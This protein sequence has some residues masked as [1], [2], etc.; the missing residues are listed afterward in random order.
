[1]GH[2]VTVFT[3]AFHD[4]GDRLSQGP[5]KVVEVDVKDRM[6]VTMTPPLLKIGR[7]I[8]GKAGKKRFDVIHVNGA[9]NFGLLDRKNGPP[10][11]ATV[12]HSA[13]EDLSDGKLRFAD[14]IRAFNSEVGFVIPWLEWFGIHLFD[15]FSAVSSRTKASLLGLYGIDPER[16]DVIWNGISADASPRTRMSRAALRKEF[17]LPDVPILLFVG[18]ID[19]RRKRLD[20]M[21]K[22]L[23]EVDK[24]LDAHLLVVGRGS[25]MF[26]E[27]LA[28]SLGILD[29]I[30]FAGFLTDE[31]LW[32]A[33]ALCDAH[34]CVSSLEGFGLTI[35]EAICARR[36]VIT[37]DVGI[38][39]EMKHPLLTVVEKSDA[40]ALAVAIIN[41]LGESEESSDV[42]EPVAVCNEF[43]W[44]RSARETVAS[45][46]RAIAGRNR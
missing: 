25:T 44:A 9:A 39:R 45:Y 19:D 32:K 40:H 12:H 16:I 11:V 42:V 1:M 46:E 30:H 43:S 36:P 7:E 6:I 24:Q 31:A 4:R 3:P 10:V 41:V 35:G 14:R 20:L 37:T 17:A 5:A 13:R 27:Q 2:E 18:R 26:A 38:A 21:I 28:I 33:Y 23:A 22:T 15:R 8:S 29:K 34:V